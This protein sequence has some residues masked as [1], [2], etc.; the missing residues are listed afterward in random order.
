MYINKTLINIRV[1]VCLDSSLTPL[2]VIYLKFIYLKLVKR[3]FL[4]P[5]TNIIQYK[6]N[7]LLFFFL[8]LVSKLSNAESKLDIHDQ[9]FLSLILKKSIN[10]RS[11]FKF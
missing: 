3:S 2:K 1:K 11:L 10:L 6:P 5:Y 4:L 9:N 8:Q 7:F